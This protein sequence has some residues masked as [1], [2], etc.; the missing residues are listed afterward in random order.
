MLGAARDPLPCGNLIKYL[1]K[2]Q[3]Q[4]YWVLK[5]TVKARHRMKLFSQNKGPHLGARAGQVWRTGQA[6][7]GGPLREGGVGN[8]E[9]L[10]RVRIIGYTNNSS[11]Y[12]RR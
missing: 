11:K 2:H 9:G 6:Y 5:L 1:N 4:R 8:Q 7:R 10:S 12:S 3:T